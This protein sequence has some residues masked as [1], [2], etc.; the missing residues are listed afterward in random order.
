MWPLFANSSAGRVAQ[1]EPPIP[2]YR[3]DR[4]FERIETVTRTADRTIE[5]LWRC[6]AALST[7]ATPSALITQVGLGDAGSGQA[8]NGGQCDDRSKHRSDS[9]AAGLPARRHGR[10]DR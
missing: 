6:D 2:I 5:L 10:R 9:S 1:Q 7:T 3:A 4:R 8:E